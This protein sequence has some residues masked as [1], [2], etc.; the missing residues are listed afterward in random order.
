MKSKQQLKAEAR[1]SA[2]TAPKSN[3]KIARAAKAEAIGVP[4][5]KSRVQ[6]VYK[7][8]E[9][10]GGKNVHRNKAEPMSEFDDPAGNTV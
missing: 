8:Q 6:P 5:G 9:N 3:P 1:K 10:V 4:H 2:Q 7:T